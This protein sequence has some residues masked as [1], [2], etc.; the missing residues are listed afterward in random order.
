MVHWRPLSV[1]MV[2]ERGTRF[3]LESCAVLHVPVVLDLTQWDLNAKSL[4]VCPCAIPGCHA[5]S[6]SPTDG[7]VDCHVAMVMVVLQS[8]L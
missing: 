6:A 3:E 2:A 1:L 8:G 5:L 4:K 7:C